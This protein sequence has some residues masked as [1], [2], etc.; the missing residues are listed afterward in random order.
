M[1]EF[2][3]LGL[4]KT[5]E[6][7]LSKKGYTQPTQIQTQGIPAVLEGKDLLAI[8][9]TGSGKTAAFS[10]P[11]LDLI[12]KTK[13]KLK[14][15]HI[16]SLVIAP[17]R[18]LAMQVEESFKE[19]GKG[20]ALSTLAVYG[21][22]AKKLQ[23]QKLAKG[24]QILVATPGRLVDLIKDEKIF[25]DEVTHLVLDEADRMLDMGFKDD[26]EFVLNKVP[27]QKQC[28]FF[29]ATMPREVEVIANKLL[30]N[31]HKIEIAPIKSRHEGIR[32]MAYLVEEEKKADFLLKFLKDRHVKSIIVFVKTKSQAN[33]LERHLKAN[34]IKACAIHSDRD[35][36]QRIYN[37]KEFQKGNMHVLVA[38]D[39]AA[40]GLDIDGVGYVLNFNL[41]QQIENYTH[42]IG[43][44]GRGGRRGIAI[45][46]ISPSEENYFK[47]IQ[48]ELGLEI[49]IKGPTK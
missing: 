20:L 12:S 33:K 25:L 4:S 32:Q 40:R 46:Y 41:P 18:E 43:R 11:I 9:Q 29:S 44:T 30:K 47:R 7:A 36:R 37:L 38:T 26:L 24:V 16:R 5:I 34:H 35:Q 42:R 39:I 10:T 49:H 6:D 23:V 8:S 13:S 22:S 48:K 3:H 28:L 27:D 45:S 1:A 2:T 21:G 31:P 14:P 19:Y 15:Y 17:T